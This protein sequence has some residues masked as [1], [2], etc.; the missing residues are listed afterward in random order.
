MK[1]VF[2]IGLSFLI[3]WLFYLWVQVFFPTLVTFNITAQTEEIF[4][5]IPKPQSSGI[6]KPQ[7]SGIPKPQSSGISKPQS[8]W[9][10]K[11]ADI[12]VRRKT[13]YKSFEGSL[14]LKPG[15]TIKMKRI[16]QG[17]LKIDLMDELEKKSVGTLFEKNGKPKEKLPDMVTIEI[18]DIAKRVEK[19]ETFL[20]FITAENAT[21]GPEMKSSIFHVIPRLL[22]GKVTMMSEMFLGKSVYNLGSISL[23][24]GDMFEVVG[25]N[26]EFQGFVSIDWQPG[27]QAVFRVQGTRGRVA[28]Y[29]SEGYELSVPFWQRIANDPSVQVFWALFIGGFGL[30]WN[31]KKEDS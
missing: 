17:P 25:D 3:C 30:Y 22:S 14:Q 7:S 29:K 2:K 18:K 31:W 28:H 10:L 6:P 16:S 19:G 23:D 8:R 26:L 21:V 11:N 24:T 20:F 9:G 27:M 15:T 4:A 5:V 13:V 12:I 1:S